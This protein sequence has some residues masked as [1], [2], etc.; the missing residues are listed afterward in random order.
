MA[1]NLSPSASAREL[2]GAAMG[3]A[4]NLDDISAVLRGLVASATELTGAA[5][6][7]LTVLDGRGE[8]ISF[9][10]HGV[11]GEIARKIRRPAGAGLLLLIPNHGHLIVD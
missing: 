3:L 7:A 1:P 9:V 5:F 4:A 2:F 6:A 8:I 10:H 11:P